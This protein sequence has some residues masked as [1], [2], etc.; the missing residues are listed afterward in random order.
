M[1]KRYALG[2]EYDGTDFV[3]WQYQDNGRSVQAVLADAVSKVADRE[4]TIHAAGRTDAGVHAAQ[5]VVHFDSDVAREPRQWL[6]GIN[7][8]LPDD[9]VVHWV[10]RV[11]ADFDAR[12]SAV[13][14]RYR[15]TIYRHG[16]RPAIARRQVWW[17][18]DELDLPAMSAASVHWLGERDFSSFRAAACQSKTPMRYL[19][20]VS[21]RQSAAFVRLEFTANAFLHHMVRNMVGALVEIGRGHRSSAWAA[22]LLAAR[23]RTLAPATAPASGL[24]LIEVVYPQRFS[25]PPARSALDGGADV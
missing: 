10:R 4:L 21:V 17:L 16:T 19:Q 8:N 12:G 24:C 1:L 23:D 3:G 2:V 15:Y 7:S 20:R 5:Q 22:Q 11:D 9:V 6:L 25:I 13:A 14:R 18:R